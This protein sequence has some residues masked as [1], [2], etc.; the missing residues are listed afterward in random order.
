M[1]ALQARKIFESSVSHELRTPLTAVLG[2]LEM[3]I[4]GADLP[5]EALQR[6]LVADRNAN[7]LRLLVSDLL[8]PAARGEGTLTLFRAP[9]DITALVQETLEAMTG[10]A[11]AAGVDLVCPRGEPVRAFVDAHRVRQVIDNLVSNAI[12]YTDSGG[13]VGVTIGTDADTVTV[14]VTDTGI[15][16]DADA[17]ERV[18]EPFYRA[19]E[20]RRRVSPGVGLGLGIARSIAHA[21]EGQLR[22]DS[23]PE[24]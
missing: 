6:L 11:R 5:E 16:M 15:G 22:A 10:A 19:D 1:H 4:D 9:A 13:R 23:R 2:H 7:R 17:L 8:D 14:T 18:W 21:H 20:A 12:K 24:E 3:L